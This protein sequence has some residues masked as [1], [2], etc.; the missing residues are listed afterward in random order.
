MIGQRNAIHW[1]NRIA[2]TKEEVKA[3][4]SLHMIHGQDVARGIVAVISNWHLAKSQRYMLTDGFVYDW[5][6]LFAGWANG[7]EKNDDPAQE[8]TEQ[9][10][11]VYELMQEEHVQALPRDV[12]TLGRCYDS[13]D[14][15][16]TFNLTPL[17]AG[18]SR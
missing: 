13:R 2:K 17:R 6:S 12:D 18:L 4:K 11:W 3:K 15:W 9:A 1:V 14:F 10:R 8:P 16:S 5:W 7:E